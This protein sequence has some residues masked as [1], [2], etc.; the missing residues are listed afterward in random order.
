ME[1]DAL[2]N[3]FGAAFSQKFAILEQI[4]KGAFSLVFSAVEKANGKKRAVKVFSRNMGKM[5]WW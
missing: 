5:F 1:Q 3:D 4:G 2:K